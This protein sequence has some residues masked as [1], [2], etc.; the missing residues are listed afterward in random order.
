MNTDGIGINNEGVAR[1]AKADKAVGLLKPA[2]KQAEQ[3]A[4]DSTNGGN[5]AAL[6]KEDAGYLLVAGSQVTKGYY[7]V[8][9]VNDEHGE[10]ANDVKRGYNKNKCEED[11]GH[12][13]LYLHNLEGVVLL[14]VAVLYYILIGCH[15]L[16]LTLYGIEVTAGLQAKLQRR[17][18][19]FEV[20]EPAR[21][22]YAGNDVLTVVLGLPHTEQGTWRIKLINGEA[23]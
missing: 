9:L 17:E 4:Y 11:V 21:K 16:Y 6:E 12:E 2:Q 20:K 23:L 13:L 22:V 14:L 18:A 8:L 1:R 5:H 3:N 19:P 7:V 10:A 15:V